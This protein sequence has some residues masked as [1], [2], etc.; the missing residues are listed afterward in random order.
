[1]TIRTLDT[2]IDKQDTF[3]IVRDQIAAILLAETAAQQVLA[4]LAIPPQDPDDWKFDVFLEASNP[5]EK[6]LNNENIADADLTP[7]VNV[8]YETS[9][10]SLGKGDVVNR[11]QPEGLFN[12]DIYGAGISEQK[13]STQDCGD[14]VA[15]FEAQ[16]MVRLA[17]NILMSAINVNLQLKGVVGRR[18]VRSVTM[19]QPQINQQTAVQIVGARILFAVEFV[20]TSPQVVGVMLDEVGYELKRA[21]DGQ[22]NLV[23]DFVGLEDE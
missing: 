17:R 10:F 16:R 11:Q 13:E 8:W 1:M 5:F 7:I 19:F 21:S 14:K 15:A 23:A 4:P 22:V 9:D 18:W 6:F 2:L 3:E 20:E 12:I